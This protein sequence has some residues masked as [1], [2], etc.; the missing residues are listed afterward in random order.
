VANGTAVLQAMQDEV[1]R[2][3]SYYTWDVG[4][5]FRDLLVSDV[6][7]TSSPLLASMYGVTPWDGKS[8]PPHF[9]G[10][11]SGL[12]TRAA[13]L[14]TGGY[15]TNPIARGLTVRRKF[16]CQDLVQPPPNSLPP[17]ALDPPP[18]TTDMTTRQRYDQKTKDQP[19]WGCHVRLNPIGDVLESFD[20]LGRYRTQERI[21]DVTTGAQLNLLN[22]DT[23]AVPQLKDG[24][25]TSVSKA[26]DLMAR[27]ADTGLV[28]ACFARNYF[29][30]TYGRQETTND[31]C[32]VD[33]VQTA[34]THAEDGSG[35]KGSIRAALRTIALDP[36]FRQRVVGPRN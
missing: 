30:F 25:M 24:D 26:G 20:A 2:L 32:A 4:G 11:R 7:L 36:N 16:L 27:I 12:L 31:G 35:G 13:F 1:S 18:F 19:C 10:N 28:E 6:S 17:G 3:T 34:L 22:I 33:R 15:E 5:D 9:D 8:P 29:R 14:V 23:S 21:L